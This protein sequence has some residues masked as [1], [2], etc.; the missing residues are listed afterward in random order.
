MRVKIRVKLESSLELYGSVFEPHPGRVAASKLLF[1]L[2]SSLRVLRM[3]DVVVLVRQEGGNTGIF[4]LLIYILSNE[5]T[6]R[7]T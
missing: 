2:Q 4:P 3:A 7:R 5:E 6:S 1:A